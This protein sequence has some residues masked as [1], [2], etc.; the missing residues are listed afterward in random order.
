MTSVGRSVRWRITVLAAGIVALVLLLAAIGVVVG[1]R[2]AVWANLDR[3]LELRAEQVAAA[4]VVDPASA[5][6]SA[7]RED[8]FAQLLDSEGRVIAASDNVEGASAL[9]AL[10]PGAQAVSTRTDLPIEDDRYRVLIRRV[11]QGDRFVVVGE[12]LD[13][14]DDGIRALAVTLAS[15]FPAVTLLLA[16]AV[17]WLVGRTLRPVEEIRREVESLGLAELDRRVTA[18]G[19]GDEI[20]RLAATMNEMLT[21]LEIAAASQRQFVADASHE[22]RTPLTRLRTALEVDLA[23]DSSDFEATCRAALG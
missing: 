16:L 2:R 4:A 12:N 7:D 18:P 8:R 5:L 23:D 3:S 14:I 21:R 20:D 1:V 22:L 10:P 17:W 6:A 9:A 13:D 11:D 19:T 15:V